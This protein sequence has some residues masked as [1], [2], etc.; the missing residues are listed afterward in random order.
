MARVA[1]GDIDPEYNDPTSPRL[2]DTLIHEGAL[3]MMPSQLNGRLRLAY[4]RDFLALP[5]ATPPE[6][7]DGEPFS[8]DALN[9]P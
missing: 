9:L 5:A 7:V 4:G 1:N 2:S 6:A 3:Q 8:A